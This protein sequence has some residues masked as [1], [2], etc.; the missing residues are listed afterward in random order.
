MIHEKCYVYACMSFDDFLSTANY[1][2]IYSWLMLYILLFPIYQGYVF[3]LTCVYYVI[4]RGH[5]QD[6][7]KE[8]FRECY[9]ELGRVRAQMK[10]VPLITLTAT[11]TAQIRSTVIEDLA[12]EDCRFITADADRTNIKYSVVN[13]TSMERSFQWMIDM[14][15][16]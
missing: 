10:G 16:E 5:S 13:I 1:K 8:P 2:N 3:I 6:K 11:S 7:K 9:K 15:M 4:S 14:L 12:M